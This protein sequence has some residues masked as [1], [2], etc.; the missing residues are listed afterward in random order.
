MAAR[1]QRLNA[2]S[3]GLTVTA[4]PLQV[5]GTFNGGSSGSD[6]AGGLTLN[7]GGSFTGSSATWS[8]GP[9]NLGIAAGSSF[10]NPGT[11]DLSAANVSTGAPTLAT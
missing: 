10:S 11:L 6:L 9:G 1:Q 2:G 8:I 4:A 3:L 7:A 5:N